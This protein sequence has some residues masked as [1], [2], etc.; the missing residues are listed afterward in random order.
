MTAK[1]L[2]AP[3][4]AEPFA[5]RSLVKY[6]LIV[7]EA[8]G[9]ERFQALLRALD[10]VAECHGCSLSTIAL[11]WVLDRP[12]VAAAM[13]GTFHGGHLVANLEALALELTEEDRATLDAA[14]RDLEDLEGDVFGL[15]RDEESPHGRILWKNLA[16]RQD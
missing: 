14:V 16:S 6:R 1:H 15:E 12:T 9:W 10:A 4:L 7:E 13:V 5:N 2:G 11:R 8:G 3:P